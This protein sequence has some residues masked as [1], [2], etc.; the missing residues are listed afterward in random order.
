M[1]FKREEMVKLKPMGYLLHTTAANAMFLAVVAMCLAFATG[2]LCYGQGQIQPQA[3]T[4]VAELHQ[5]AQPLSK[6]A[7]ADVGTTP[8]A[9]PGPSVQVSDPGMALA[10]EKELAAMKVRMEQIGAQLAE[11]KS[12]GPATDP[13]LAAVIP[14]TM[15]GAVPLAAPTEAAVDA[16]AAKPEKPAP[17]EPFAFADWTWLNGTA[18]NKDA[19]TSSA[20]SI[21]RKMTL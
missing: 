2:E 18:R 3:Q 5:P 19:V 7:A 9:A 6:V 11:L 17:S 4:K 12:R 20:V 14:A 21:T 8:S 16:S 13:S 10:L 1:R 15:S